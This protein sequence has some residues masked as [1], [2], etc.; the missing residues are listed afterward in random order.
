M[1]KK[2]FIFTVDLEDWFQVENLKEVIK[3]DTWDS[4]ELRVINNTKVLL[5]LFDEYAIKCTFFVLGWIAEKV[6][7]LIKEIHEKKHEIA[8][9]GYAHKL[10][11]MQTPKEF[12]ED[13]IKSK[14]I[15]EDIIGERVIGY[16]APSFSIADWAIDILKEN[17][18]IY[19][20]SYYPFNLHN[21]YGGFEKIYVMNE[22]KMFK[23]PNGLIEV[24]I[25]TLK[26]MNIHIPWGGGAYFRI[27]PYFI[28]RLGMRSI[29]GRNNYYLFYFH[30]WE[31]DYWQPKI[32]N[33]KL[34]YRIRHYTGLK[35]SCNKLKKLFKE[36][37][38]TS[39]ADFLNTQKEA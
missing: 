29:F 1:N 30:P 2:K 35:K 14:K 19:D 25:S 18:F 16:R 5:D 15:L 8:S 22:N 9:H 24:P 6:P 27:L 37:Q 28:F 11:P 26:F 38:F 7:S 13:I 32:K 17:G 10:I 23:F 39:I 21:R 34:N 3:S 33:I 36:F 4:Y 20:S 12:E 31:I